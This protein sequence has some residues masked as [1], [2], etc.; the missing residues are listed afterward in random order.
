MKLLSVPAAICGLALSAVVAFATPATGMVTTILARVTFDAID[1]GQAAGLEA[2]IQDITIAP[3]GHTGWHTHPGGT[4]IL[5]GSG[6]FT[7]Y[8]DACEATTLAAGRGVFEPGG[9]IQLTRNEGTEPLFLDVV[10][11]D[12]PVGG[13]VRSDAEAPGCAAEAELPTTAMGTGVTAAIVSRAVFDTAADV[14]AAAERDVVIQQVSIAPGGHSGWHSHPGATVIFVQSGTLTISMADDCQ[15]VNYAAGQGVVEPGGQVQLAKNDS[16]VPLE[17]F[18]A[19][20]DV[21]VGREAEFRIDEPEPSNCAGLAPVPT[22]TP[23]P[24][25][26][27][28]P[29]PN[30]ALAE[31]ESSN[32][33]ASV[34]AVFLAVASVAGL[35]AFGRPRR[36]RRE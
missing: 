14:M 18:V 16:T 23:T 5:V 7:L 20:F 35:V 17:L 33:V 1:T 27:A 8:N 31:R 32:P 30:A 6:V 3:G 22:S 15:A 26:P 4:V 34:G 21:P 13:A 12:V 2:V 36:R 9:Q 29:L 28:A 24:A 19:F 10:Y 11:F 25:P